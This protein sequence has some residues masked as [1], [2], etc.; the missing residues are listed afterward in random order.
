MVG[1]GQVQG[2][3]D[4]L[5][6]GVKDARARAFN[7]PKDRAPQYAELSALKLGKV[8]A[9]SESGSPPTP[10]PVQAPRLEAAPAPLE[11]GQQTVGLSV[12]VI[13]SSP[14]RY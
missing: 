10:T 1:S 6:A 11:P 5:T 12:T 4:M 8:I 7:D 9:I 2:T 3:P 14:S 13:V